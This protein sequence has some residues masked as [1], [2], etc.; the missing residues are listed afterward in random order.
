MHFFRSSLLTALAVLT[1]GITS[2]NAAP[3]QDATLLNA[4]QVLSELRTAPDQNAPNWLLERAYAVAVLPNVI[5]ASL[6]AGGRRGSGVMVIRQADGSWSNPVFINITGGS[7][8]LQWGVQSTDLMLVFTSKASVEGLVGGKVT[9]GADASVAAGPVGRQTAAATDL[10]LNAQVY[11]YSRTKGLFIGIA[12]DGS[13]LTIDNTSNANFYGKP[14]ILASEITAAGAA[15][16]HESANAF[17]AA[18]G[19]NVAPTPSSTP[20][21]AAVPAPA[22][23]TQPDNQSSGLVTYPMEDNNAGAEPPL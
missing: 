23:N 4:T 14:G 3:R 15:H 7:L 8:G 17:I 1:L 5:K 6:I 12:L 11:S 16:S 10:S 13:A 20:A 21:P 9:L 22:T 19:G 2:S 18:L